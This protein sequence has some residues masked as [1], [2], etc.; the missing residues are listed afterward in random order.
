MRE[1]LA[2][3][4]MREIAVGGEYWLGVET[5]SDEEILVVVRESLM[6]IWHA[7]GT[8]QT[9]RGNNEMAVVDMEA[10][11]LG[12]G[13]VRVM[14][15]SAMPILLPGHPASTICKFLGSVGGKDADG[16]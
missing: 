6:M 10:T 15:A 8:C 11:A 3:D 16:A 2:S 13:G 5:A 4:A 7:E 1:I 12:V 9:R 14:D